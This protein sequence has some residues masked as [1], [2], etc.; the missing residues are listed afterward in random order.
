MLSTLSTIAKRHS[1]PL[2]FVLAYGLSWVA[3]PWIGGL[4]PWGPALAAFIMLA[5]TEG[6]PGVKELLG[7]MGRWRVG[8]IWYVIALSLPILTSLGAA[9]LN[10]MLGAAASPLEPWY[11]ILLLIPLFLLLG[12]EWE[13]PGWS[14]YALPRLQAGRSALL[15]SLILSV[16]RAGWHLPLFLYGYI[17]WAD[18]P[19]IIAAQ[20]IITWLYNSTRRSVFIVMALHLM[21]NVS[22]EYFG[23]M[24][25]GENAVNFVWLKGA[26]FGAVVLGVIVWGGAARLSRPASVQLETVAEPVG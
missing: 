25:S 23:P 12:G 15:A 3:V 16:F 24:F 22:G 7:Q 6:K 17:Y 8:L 13:E 21:M 1:L 18:I 14:G 2:F 20:I 4:L 5:L 9:G 26:I 19:F 10:V 11:N